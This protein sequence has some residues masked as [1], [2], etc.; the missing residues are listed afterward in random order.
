[1]PIYLP[2]SRPFEQGVSESALVRFF[3][4]IQNSQLE[5]HSMM[6]VRHGHVVAEHWWQPFG[7]DK[8]HMLFS[9]SKSFT[10]S[11]V[12]FAVTEGL[13]TEDD[14]VVD[15]FPGI[16]TNSI[17]DNMGSMKIRH[18]LSMST[19]HVVDT[20]P[21]L[22]ESP[23]GDWIKAFFNVPI[24]KEPGSHF[25]Y[26]TGATYM[27]SAI[28]QNV[29]GQSLLA[30]LTPRLF[31]PL[32]I[33]NPTWETCPRGIP[34][35]GYGLSVRTED[36]AK[37]GQLYLQKGSWQGKQILPEAWIETATCKHVQNESP[38]SDWAEGY[39]YQFWRCR[40]S[41]YRGDGKYGQ[42]CVVMPDLDAVLA[43]TSSLHDMQ[44]VLDIVWETL[45]PGMRDQSSADAK[46]VDQSTYFGAAMAIPGP[47]G[48]VPAAVHSTLWAE[49]A[50][51]LEPNSLGIETLRFEWNDQGFS[52]HLLRNGNPVTLQGGF[53]AWVEQRVAVISDTSESVAIQGGWQSDKFVFAMCF[54]ETPFTRVVEI[55]G[56]PNHVVL[57]ARSKIYYDELGDIVLTGKVV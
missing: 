8:P 7:Q 57:T 55:A 42:Y 40:H 5:L 6:L 1:M 44:K 36:I 31:E 12:G 34:V 49:R 51:A 15:F 10:S 26:N 47:A 3:Q 29:T 32:G 9:L 33:T 30:Y 28:L 4:S 45:L 21:F 43:I 38:N 16:V 2:R 23:D 25:L 11:A 24:E 27:L 37:F 54:N 53:E 41:A 22:K 20:M 50:I 46:E 13:L 35:G 19:G 52:I 18:L 39:G 48:T 14:F 17:R 56:E